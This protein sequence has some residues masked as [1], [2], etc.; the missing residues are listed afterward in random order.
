MD[1]FGQ[2]SIAKKNMRV[3]LNVLN[4]SYFAQKVNNSIEKI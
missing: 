3:C 1:Y 2:A 4:M